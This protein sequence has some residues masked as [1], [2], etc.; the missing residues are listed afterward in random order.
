MLTAVGEQCILASL[1]H[2]G[3][4]YVSGDDAKPFLQSQL[5]NDINLL[6][7]HHVQISAYCN[8]KGRMFAQL[9]IVP[10]RDGYLL[11]LPH[12]L[13]NKITTRLRMFVLR[14]A[15]TLEDVTEQTVCLGILGHDIQANLPSGWPS[16]PTDD[17]SS[18]HSELNLIIK[19]PGTIQRYLVIAPLASASAIWQ[20][21]GSRFMHSGS[22]IWIWSD[23]QAGL[24]SVW[25]PTIEEFVPQMLNLDI[26]DGVNFKKGCYPGQEIVARMHYLGKAKRRMF[27][28]HGPMETLPKPGTDLYQADGDGQSAGQ[29]VIAHPAKGDGVE[30][31]AVLQLTQLKADLRLGEMSGPAL[32]VLPLPYPVGEDV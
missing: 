22:G 30:M 1:D 5:S 2:Y 10:Y 29:V 11:L 26:L 31:L 20:E 14:S 21:L 25:L 32:T 24:P 16:L 9:L 13:V 4:I 12:E 15:V 28:L 7:A 6:D 27:R 3:A 8:P 17:Y 18:V 23:I 19:I